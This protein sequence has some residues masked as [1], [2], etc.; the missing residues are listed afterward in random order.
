MPQKK[1]IAPFALLIMLLTLGCA[2]PSIPF[3]DSSPAQPAAPATVD[4]DTLATLVADSVSQKV[5]Q[6]LEAL[7]PTST[8]T[9]LPTET[10]QPSPTPTDIPPTATATPIDYPEIGSDL[11]AENGMPVYYDYNGGYKVSLPANWLAIR[12]GEVEYTETWGLPIAA[13]PEVNGALQSM[14]SLD[15]NRFRLF[16]LDVQ[17]G[18]FDTGFL[19]NISI[20]SMPESEALL[21]EVFAQAVLELPN[22]IV[23][24]VVTDSRIDKNAAEERMGI[25]TAEW[26][27]QLASSETV[28]LYQK[29]A[30][31]V[32]KKRAL[33]VTFTSTVDFKDTLLPEMNALIDS[34]TPLR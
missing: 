24:L 26:D 23:G 18:H 25:V 10:P 27:A 4:A 33:L 7:P 20:I 2:L 3:L 12:P 19:S 34:L 16:M 15:P 17:D 28:H 22:T 30:I 29:Q 1:W 21:D 6:T 5:A 8:P 11:L 9:P 13:Y 32:I 14:Q 31:F